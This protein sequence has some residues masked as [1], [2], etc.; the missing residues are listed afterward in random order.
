M[1]N[2]PGARHCNRSPGLFYQSEAHAIPAI[3][4][5]KTGDRSGFSAFSRRTRCWSKKG[6]AMEPGEGHRFIER[7]RQLRGMNGSARSYYPTTASYFNGVASR[8]FRINGLMGVERVTKENTPN[9]NPKL[10]PW[11]ISAIA[12]N[13]Q[14]AATVLV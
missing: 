1:P 9:E 3:V 14:R 8:R 13:T 5:S 10:V 11:E 7:I 12:R 4:D 2:F 6:P